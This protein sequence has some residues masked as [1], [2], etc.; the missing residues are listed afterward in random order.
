M[1][2]GK[3]VANATI[4]LSKRWTNDAGEECER[5]SFV[6]F[7][8]FDKRAD[9]LAEFFRAGD[10]ITIEGELQQE[11]WEKDG[12][13]RS[14]LKVI[15]NTFHFCETK[16]ECAARRVRAQSRKES[17]TEEARKV[18]EAGTTPATLPVNAKHAPAQA[19]MPV[20]GA[21][22]PGAYST[23]VPF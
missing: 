21:G 3:S 20:G 22:R 2:S 7:T 1:P 15:A 23:D 9:A 4:A 13:K 14:R 19:E 6:D 10:P 16:D 18:S 17:E 12:E 5:V 11:N 8:V